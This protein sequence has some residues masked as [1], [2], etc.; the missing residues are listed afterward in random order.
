MEPVR[1][2]PKMARSSRKLLRDQMRFRSLR[3]QPALIPRNSATH[4]AASST[5]RKRVAGNKITL[6][7]ITPTATSKR[8][9]K[10]DPLKPST[11]HLHGTLLTSSVFQRRG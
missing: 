11:N 9:R 4:P 10:T 3:F 2:A 8:Q 5:S 7:Y 6:G 1:G